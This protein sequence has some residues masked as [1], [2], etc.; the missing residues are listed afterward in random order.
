MKRVSPIPRKAPEP[1]ACAPSQT[2]GRTRWARARPHLR[3][4]R[5][6]EGL[7][8]GG[9]RGEAHRLVTEPR[10]R[11]E[12]PD[13][14]IEHGEHRARRDRGGDARAERAGPRQADPGKVKPEE[15]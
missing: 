2:C 11:R 10:H 5:E 13:R 9:P 4:K 1:T 7:P 15:R 12:A 3:E 14:D 8:G 6:P